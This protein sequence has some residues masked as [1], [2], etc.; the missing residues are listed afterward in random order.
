MISFCRKASITLLL[1][2][3]VACVLVLPVFAQQQSDPKVPTNPLV[4]LLQ[5]KGI[6][7]PEEAALVTQ[8]VSPAESNQLLAKVLLR[9]GLITEE[10][11]NQTVADSVTPVVAQGSSDAR[12]I[13]AVL[14]IPP[15]N[16]SGSTPAAVPQAPKEPPVIPAVVPLRVL[17]IDIPKQGESQ[18]LRLR[19][20]Q[21]GL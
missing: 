7:T 19:Q 15:R 8:A 21:R 3:L 2:A 16:P 1:F 6:L 9:K 10:E 20:S 13:P 14:R 17:P 18:D 11:F 4:Q 12:M 5:T